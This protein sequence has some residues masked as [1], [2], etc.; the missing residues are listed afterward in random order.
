MKRLDSRLVELAIAPSRSK[1]QALIAAAEVEIFQ[2]GEWIVATDQSLNAEHLTPDQVRLKPSSQTLKYVSRGGLKLEAALGHLKL[3][4][5]GLR[6]LDVGI[7]TGGF[8]DGLLQAGA[9]AVLGIDVGHGQLNEKL[10]GDKRLM[11]LEGVHIKN[12]LDHAEV[13]TWLSEG[14]N[15]CVIDVS[16]I[17][18]SLVFP[19]LQS[20]LPSG[21]A[22]LAL[23]KPQ[24]EVGPRT[25]QPEMF[26]EIETRIL[27]DL[28]KCGFSAVEY[29]PSPVRGQDGSQEFFVWARR[30]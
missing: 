14:V 22:V 27:T 3:N 25:V 4:V 20:A 17:S 12:L 23:V 13:R 2:R 19:V 26:G 24:F 29:F 10:R 30:R 21:C 7:S 6:C 5:Q 9:A 16:F 15:L 18:L 28:D 11:A 8:A 1:A